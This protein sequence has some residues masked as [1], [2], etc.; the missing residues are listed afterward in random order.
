MSR[1][2]RTDIGVPLAPDRAPWEP[3]PGESS[4]W[5]TRFAEYLRLGPTRTMQRVRNNLCAEAGKTSY[6][7]GGHWSRAAQ[8]WR[9]RE[10][11]RAWDADQ[12][13]RYAS[14]RRTMEIALHMRR[15]EIYNEGIEMCLDT[16]RAANLAA[17]TQEQARAMFGQMSRFLIKLLREERIECETYRYLDDEDAAVHITADDLIAAQRALQHRMHAIQADPNT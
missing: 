13:Q 4:I 3:Q 14:E 17:M 15:L 2:P 10:R 6:K 8:K 12:C 9:W 5:Y 7:C 1:P 16:L 11:A